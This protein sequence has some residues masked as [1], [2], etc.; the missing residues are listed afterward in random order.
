MHHGIIPFTI[1]RVI[2]LIRVIHVFSDIKL[3][4]FAIQKYMIWEWTEIR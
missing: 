1:I 2:R 4:T 3:I